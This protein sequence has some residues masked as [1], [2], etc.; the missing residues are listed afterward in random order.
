MCLLL[1]QISSLVNNTL[2]I[3]N[4]VQL[5]DAEGQ[6]NHVWFYK[7]LG[8]HR[9]SWQSLNQVKVSLCQNTE[10]LRQGIALKLLLCCE[11]PR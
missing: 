8:Q 2:I 1:L 9:L 6:L 4:Y 10:F 5:P 11:S 3:E 7:I